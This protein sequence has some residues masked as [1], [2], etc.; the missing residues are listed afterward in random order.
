MVGGYLTFQGI[1][2]KGK[3]AGSAVEDVLPV[4]LQT[5]DDRVERPEGIEPRVVEAHAIVGGLEET[6][7]A[8]LGYNRVTARPDAQR[9][10]PGRRGRAAGLPRGREWPDDRLHHGL[11]ATLVPAAVRAVA[12]LLSASGSRWSAGRPGAHRPPLL[13]SAGEA[14]R[15]TSSWSC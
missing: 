11:R 6:W 4:T 12:G 8:V 15:Y 10:G 5:G 13:L 14:E 9:A 3:W 1:E 7:P 2:G